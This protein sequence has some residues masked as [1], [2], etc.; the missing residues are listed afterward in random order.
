[1]SKA[2][3]RQTY[4]LDEVAVSIWASRA[5]FDE[6]NQPAMICGFVRAVEAEAEI[7]MG[8]REGDGEVGLVVG[9]A[10]GCGL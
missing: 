9:W 8:G 4:R 6:L 2:V 7:G 3:S 10:G 1:V 5:E